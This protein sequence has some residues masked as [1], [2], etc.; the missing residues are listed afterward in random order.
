MSK[1]GLDSPLIYC[2]QQLAKYVYS[3]LCNMIRA[4][5]EHPLAAEFGIN[6]FKEAKTTLQFIQFRSNN[7]YN[8][9]VMLST[10]VC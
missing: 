1:I 3:I 6:S 7:S 10:F 9:Q 8:T 4:H 5:N 2:W